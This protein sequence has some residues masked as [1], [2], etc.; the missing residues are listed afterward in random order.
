M[1]SAWSH[2]EKLKNVKKYIS[3]QQLCTYKFY[4]CDRNSLLT[5]HI[6][7]NIKVQ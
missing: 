5:E 6:V 3:S 2:N 7:I 4:G 1:H